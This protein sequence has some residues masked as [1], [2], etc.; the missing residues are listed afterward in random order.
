MPAKIPAQLLNGLSEAQAGA[1][2]RFWNDLDPAARADLALLYDER[3]ET[4]K[5]LRTE[6]PGKK[7]RWWKLPVRVEGRFV[8]R[9]DPEPR[10]LFP[11]LDF[12]EYL[13]NHEVYLHELDGTRHHICSAHERA[14]ETLRA[15]LIPATFSCPL[16]KEG[17]PMRKLLD[18]AQ[19]RSIALSLVAQSE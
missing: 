12:Y 10:D 1:V 2:R 17:C 19:G 15:G 6:G 4:C 8:V 3:N 13:I 5:Y 7:T 16:A 9:A 11:S 14:R 18:V